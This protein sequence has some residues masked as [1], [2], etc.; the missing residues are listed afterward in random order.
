MKN[1]WNKSDPHAHVGVSFD[2]P[3]HDVHIML[4]TTGAGFLLLSSP[5]VAEVAAAPTEMQ[6]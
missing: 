5:V 1:V 3:S 6:L 4:S 2:V